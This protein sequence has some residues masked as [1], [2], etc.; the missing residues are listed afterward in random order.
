MN[1][2]HVCCSKSSRDTKLSR[3]LE[4]MG[5][6]HTLL[7]KAL[8]ENITRSDFSL[9]DTIIVKCAK[10]FVVAWNQYSL[11]SRPHTLFR[12]ISSIQKYKHLKLLRWKSQ[13]L[14]PQNSLIFN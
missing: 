13:N 3:I 9:L 11:P 12:H 2:L 1:S 4:M 10:A 6:K 7:S 14:C 5:N 8:T